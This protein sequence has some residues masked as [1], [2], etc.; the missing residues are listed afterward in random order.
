MAANPVRWFEI[1]VADMER[2]RRFYEQLFQ[3]RLEKLPVQGM[4]YWAFPSQDDQPGVGG[5]LV[6]MEGAGPGGGGTLIY[7]GCDD[8]AVEEGRV[9]GLGGSVVLPKMSIEPYGFLSLVNDSE[10]NRIGLHS[11][12]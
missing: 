11:L 2:A 9:A 4:D 1:Y 5:A 7:F 3:C 10:G 6:R 8:C 12:R